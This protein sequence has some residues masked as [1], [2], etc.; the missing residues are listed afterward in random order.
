MQAEKEA[1]D[2]LAETLRKH[3]QA[4]VVG[5]DSLALWCPSGVLCEG[6]EGHGAER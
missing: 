6:D 1:E 2:L 5:E 3:L 4:Y